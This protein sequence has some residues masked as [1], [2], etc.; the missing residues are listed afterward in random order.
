MKKV[1]V[2]GSCGAG[3]ST[4]AKRLSKKINLP[5]ISLDFYYWK[6]EWT[7][8]PTEEWRKKV[9]ELVSGDEWIIEGN[10]QNTFDIKFPASDT[11][12]VLDINRFI[13]FWRIWKRRIL[14]N[15]VDKLDCCKERITWRLARWV[16]W[17]YPR[18]GRSEIR[19]YIAK[20]KENKIIILK[21]SEE[22]EKFLSKYNK[23]A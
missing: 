20:C 16:L 13:C 23:I 3:K 4:F 10:Y 6:P 22:A 7:T 1:S 9:T 19:K 11:I 17:D 18:I 2:I 15:R 12:I 21:S 5:L 14:K 8:T